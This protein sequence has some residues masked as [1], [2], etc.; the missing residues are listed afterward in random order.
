MVS[1]EVNPLL[2]D[3]GRPDRQS[4]TGRRIPKTSLLLGP[5]SYQPP[6]PLPLARQCGLPR[7][8]A[9][10]AGARHCVRLRSRLQP[11]F[12]LHHGLLLQSI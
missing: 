9:I 3:C 5:S 11:V 6:P 8:V 12:P 4:D 7:R 1:S 10:C 2:E